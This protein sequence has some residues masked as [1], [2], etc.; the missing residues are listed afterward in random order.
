MPPPDLRRDRAAVLLAKA[1]EN[2]AMVDIALGRPEASSSVMGFLLQ[3]AAEKLMKAVLASRGIA[4]ERTHSLRQLARLL[5]RNSLP[6]PED[7]AGVLDLTPFAVRYRYDEWRHEDA[8]LDQHAV[9]DQ[10]RRLRAWA[11]EQ[12]E[13]AAGK[14]P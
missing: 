4:Y 11:E 12:I 10:V 8:P 1:A 13:L 3:Q 6:V 7:A 9:R 5:Q 2:E 14:E